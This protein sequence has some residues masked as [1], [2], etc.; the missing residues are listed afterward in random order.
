MEIWWIHIGGM[1]LCC[2]EDWRCKKISLWKIFLYGTLVLGTE[3]GKAVLDFE[4]F[5]N[6][7]GNSVAG[8]LPGLFFLFLSKATKEQI[9]YGDGLLLVILGIS[10]GIEHMVWLLLLALFLVFFAAACFFLRGKR[11]ERIP[12]TPFLF[13][14]MAVS[15]FWN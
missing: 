7:C 3:A 11:K 5:R 14:G 10:L 13:L 6:R 9:G 8:A 15:F 12:F 4:S 2:V 1:L